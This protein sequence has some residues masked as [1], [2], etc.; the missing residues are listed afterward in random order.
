MS[1]CGFRMI[2]SHCFCESRGQ[3]GFEDAL[4][5]AFSGEMAQVDGH[6]TQGKPTVA[7]MPSL[8]GESQHEPL[9]A[10]TP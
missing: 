5:L 3:N 6:S 1:A 4:Q 7:P 9:V 8:K 2:I 10:H